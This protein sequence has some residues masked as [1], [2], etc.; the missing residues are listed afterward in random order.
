MSARTLFGTAGGD[1]TLLLGDCQ[2]K[3][4]LNELPQRHSAECRCR[5]CTP[6]QVV[7]D[8]VVDAAH[9]A[10]GY[11]LRCGA[12]RSARSRPTEALP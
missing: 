2:L 3:R 12:A 5:L 1:L 10:R 11:D 7:R 9:A 6:M 8:L 4:P